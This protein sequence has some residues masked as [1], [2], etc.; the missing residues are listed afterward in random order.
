MFEPPGPPPAAAPR[1]GVLG[2]VMLGRLV[3][4]AVATGVPPAELWSPEVLERCAALDLLV[5]NLECCLSDRGE[6]TRLIAGKPFFFRGPPAAVGALNAVRAGV[7]SLANN[8]A[9]DFGPLAA[10]DTV[11]ELDAAGIAPV[12]AGPDATEARRPAIVR[13]GHLSVGVVA[14]ADHPEEYGAGAARPG[15][16]FAPLHEGA[17]GWLLDAVAEARERFDVVLAFPHWGP[18]MT[19]EPAPWQRAVAAELQQAGADLVAGHS[20][21]AFHGIGWGPRGPIAYDLGGALD[22]YAVDPDLRNDLGLLAIWVPAESH[23]LEIIGLRIEA[24]RTR[25]AEGRDAAWIGERLASACA[26][27]GSRVEPAPGEAH[28]WVTPAG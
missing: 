14:V 9:L 2:D 26:D 3:G 13:A 24:C 12:G 16:A 7:A 25:I 22:D 6:P 21:H 11:A 17:P 15:T 10:M 8:H 28:W 18:N 4:E 27:L 1:I 23:R 5:V 19:R 20:A